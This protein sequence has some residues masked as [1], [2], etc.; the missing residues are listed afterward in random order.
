MHG[1]ARAGPHLLFLGLLTLVN[2][3]FDWLALGLTRAFLRRGLALGGRG[4]FV[5]AV[6]D[7][8]V[9]AFLVVALALAAVI[10]VQI[11]D[12]IAVFSAGPQARVLPLASLFDGLANQPGDYEYWWVW[13]MLF[14]TQIPSVFNLVVAACALAR[15][16][17]PLTHWI[18][19]RMPD[20]APVA[21]KDR[22]LVAAALAVQIA[23]G[24]LAAG[25]AL[26]V[27]ALLV[28]PRAL[29]F[30]GD[31]I[32]NVSERLAIYNAPAHTIRWLLGGGW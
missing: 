21:A 27:L 14:S 3:P 9:G 31:V 18:V 2:A 24:A 16:F 28:L 17:G 10:A 12:D 7:A 22:L 8:I 11:F 5:Y 19:R 29:P 20:G 26:Y 30:L 13:A 25:L 15:G 32:R 4:P 1:W 23:G 6:I